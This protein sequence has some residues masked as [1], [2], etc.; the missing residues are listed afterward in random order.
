M[1]FLLKIGKGRLKFPQK[2]IH[3]G[4]MLA[5][6]NGG[7]EE[8]EYAMTST[9]SS[10]VFLLLL[11]WMMMMMMMMMD[12]DDDEEEEEEDDDIHRVLP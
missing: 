12:D 9:M 8:Y 2:F 7:D 3:L 6:E 4:K 1:I 10:L 11:V 5:G